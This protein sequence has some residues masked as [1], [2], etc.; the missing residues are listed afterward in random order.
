M[1]AATILTSVPLAFVL[2]TPVHAQQVRTGANAFGTWQADAP[3]VSRQI[4]PGDLPPPSLTEND[5]EA[6]DFENMA[7]VVP[8]PQGKLPAVPQGFN[9]QVFAQGL[10]QPRVIRVA[11]NGDIFVAESG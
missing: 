2:L 9:V 4:R 1:R 10:N 5:P 11:P 6:P 7:K 3:G 8:E